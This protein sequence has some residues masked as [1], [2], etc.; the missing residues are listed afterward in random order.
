VLAPD[1]FSPSF[2]RSIGAI[3]ALPGTRGGSVAGQ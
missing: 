2:L 3:L 1:D